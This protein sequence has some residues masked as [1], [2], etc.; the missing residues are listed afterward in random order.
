MAPLP[1]S[2]ELKNRLFDALAANTVLSRLIDLYRPDGAKGGLYLAYCHGY[3]HDQVWVIIDRLRTARRV[4][5][6]LRWDAEY[7]AS[8][9]LEETARGKTALMEQVISATSSN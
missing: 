7:T 3:N 1:S 6:K 9:L 4:S 5:A 8:R 2:V